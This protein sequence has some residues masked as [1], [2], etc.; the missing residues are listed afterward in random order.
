MRFSVGLPDAAVPREPPDTASPSTLRCFRCGR[1]ASPHPRSPSPGLPWGGAWVFA[2]GRTLPGAARGPPGARCSGEVTRCWPRRGERSP[3]GP[4]PSR[5][6]QEGKTRLGTRPPS[7]SAGALPWAP[8]SPAR[9]RGGPDVLLVEELGGTGAAGRPPPGEDTG[10]SRSGPPGAGL[11]T[12]SWGRH[13]G[14]FRPHGRGAQRA[15]FH[16]RSGD[17]PFRRPALGRGLQE[18]GLPSGWDG[19]DFNELTSEG[20]IIGKALGSNKLSELFCKKLWR[21]GS[22]AGSAMAV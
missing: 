14:L 6:G 3:R 19:S 8:L 11:G 10:R 4:G 22:K 15:L 16:S 17:K 5:G 20:R 13:K 9:A 1:A 18:A 7:A 21:S 2:A 12:G